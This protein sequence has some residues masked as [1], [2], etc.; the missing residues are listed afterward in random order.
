MIP[1]GFEYHR[2]NSVQE[3][4]ALLAQLGEEARPLAGGHRPDPGYEGPVCQRPST[5]SI[6]LE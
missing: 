2:P 6:S 3:A 5:S 1:S 4:V